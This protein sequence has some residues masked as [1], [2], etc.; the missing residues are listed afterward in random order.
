MTNSEG[1][2]QIY[3]NS[4]FEKLFV[5]EDSR[6]LINSVQEVLDQLQ[7][8]YGLYVSSGV[9]MNALSKSEKQILQDGLLNRGLSVNII[10]HDVW[11]VL[12]ER[13]ELVVT[14]YFEEE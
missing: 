7:L 13:K 6:L 2:I 12:S 4:I 14:L 5:K 3:K 11:R 10:N 8:N 1:Q 9:D